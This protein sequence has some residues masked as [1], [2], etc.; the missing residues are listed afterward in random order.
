MSDDKKNAA[1]PSAQDAMETK[2]RMEA[3]ARAIRDEM[4]S[5]TQEELERLYAAVVFMGKEKDD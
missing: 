4:G 2:K 5:M 1:P 3:L